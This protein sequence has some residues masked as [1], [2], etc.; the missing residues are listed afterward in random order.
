MEDGNGADGG[1]D[2]AVDGGYSSVYPDTTVRFDRWSGCGINV[3]LGG[4]GAAEFVEL[5]FVSKRG[6]VEAHYLTFSQ[7]EQLRAA[8]DA[9]MRKDVHPTPADFEP[10]ET[11]YHV[12]GAT[13]SNGT[14]GEDEPLEEAA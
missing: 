10:G 9:V 12:I 5:A 2:W 8:V 13:A 6:T 7:A 11:H 3:T 1:I 14:A 4:D